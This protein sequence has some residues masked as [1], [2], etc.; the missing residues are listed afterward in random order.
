M[1]A[2]TWLLARMWI[3]LAYAVVVVVA[4]AIIITRTGPVYG[5]WGWPTMASIALILGALS[6]A[7]VGELLRP[8]NPYKNLDPLYGML[9]AGPTGTLESGGWG[10]ML[11][12]VPP[13]IAAAMLMVVF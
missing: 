1:H 7:G 10:W 3:G 8:Q 13:L 2:I 12:V 11:Q 6:L 9:D 5:V 4:S